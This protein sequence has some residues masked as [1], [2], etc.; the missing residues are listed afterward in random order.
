MA[1]LGLY[2][3]EMSEKKLWQKKP[4]RGYCHSEGEKNENNAYK[5]NKQK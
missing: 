4:K 5:I 1:E 3:R 2:T